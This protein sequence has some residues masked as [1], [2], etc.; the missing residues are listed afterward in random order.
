MPR[1]L[2]RRASGVD[3]IYNPVKPI[4]DVEPETEKDTPQEQPPR[5]RRSRSAREEETTAPP[6]PRGGSSD[7]LKTGRGWAAAA[8]VKSSEYADDFTPTEEE[9]VVKFLEDSPFAVY[10][11]HWVER[12]K[13]LKKSFRCIEN[14]CPLCDG[15]NSAA[16]RIAF[17]I[18]DFS[19]PDAP[20][21][22]VYTVPK[23]VC[24]RIETLH[25]SHKDGPING[26]DR[27]FAVSRVASTPY[28][29]TISGIKARDL[30]EDFGFDPL[31][32]AE[33]DNFAKQVSDDSILENPS[34]KELEGIADEALD[35]E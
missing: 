22:K 3:R 27:Y 9:T 11:Q 16:P 6:R 25:K 13:G 14:D 15:G 12:G 26:V 18:I 23:K 1:T 17:N 31:T 7:T 2:T 4:N 10:Y 21:V 20:K 28:P 30:K 8:S 19:D 24:T 32:E 5:A 33:I 34:R 29:T 35:N